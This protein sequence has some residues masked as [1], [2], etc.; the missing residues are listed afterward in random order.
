MGNTTEDLMFGLETI[1]CFG[2]CGQAP[3]VTVNEDIYGHFRVTQVPKLIKKYKE[4]GS[5][6]TK[7]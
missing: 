7:A 3:V 2:C 1:S 4:V 6:K 5:A